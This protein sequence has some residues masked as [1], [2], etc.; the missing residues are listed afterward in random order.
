MKS[1]SVIEVKN[2]KDISYL[3]IDHYQQW[4]GQT[5]IYIE[6]LFTTNSLNPIH[7]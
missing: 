6:V 3:H 7:F 4:I 2:E 1:S 5:D